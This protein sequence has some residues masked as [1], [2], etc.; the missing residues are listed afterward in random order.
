MRPRRLASAGPGTVLV[1]VTSHTHRT[2][3]AA[4]PGGGVS[5]TPFY[6]P[7]SGDATACR[8]SASG[9]AAAPD[10]PALTRPG[11]GAGSAASIPRG[12]EAHGTARQLVRGP[13]QPVRS[14]GVGRSAVPRQAEVTGV[15]CATGAPARGPP[16]PA[17]QP[18]R[19]D[20][21][22]PVSVPAGLTRRKQT[23]CERL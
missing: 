11:P 16:A 8:P 7:V 9:G 2:S 13:V 15:P 4:V 1:C 22:W 20:T 23:D 12:A 6:R 17:Q 14:P 3:R 5:L 21:G 19:R 10:A 18:P